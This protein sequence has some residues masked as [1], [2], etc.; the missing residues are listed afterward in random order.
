MIGIHAVRPAAIRDVFLTL[1]EGL[2]T[3]LEVIDRN[4]DRPRDVTSRILAR[5]ARV[6]DEDPFC[7]GQ[8]QQFTEPDRLNIPPVAEMLLHETVDVRQ[9][10][11]GC[12]THDACELEHFGVREAVMDEQAVFP[13]LDEGGSFEHLQ[14][15]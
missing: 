12:R 15:L 6:D 1:R 11:F 13:A 8:L 2:Q 4:R 14:V 10:P 3:T 7:A 5:R 9:S